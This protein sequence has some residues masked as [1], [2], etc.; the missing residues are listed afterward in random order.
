MNTPEMAATRCSVT[1]QMTFQETN[2]DELADL[3]RLAIELGVDRVKGHHLWTHFDQTRGLS[4]RRDSEAIQRWNA[5]VIEARRVAAE[6]LLPNGKPILLENF[7]ELGE[8]APSD[9]AP[10]GPCPFL[11]QEAWVSADRTFRPVLRTGCATPHTWH[12]WQ[13]PRLGAHGDLE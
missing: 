4:M 10:G 8:A 2:V 5:A 3:V 7:F 1:F 13:P 11:G 12:F 6:H 9:L